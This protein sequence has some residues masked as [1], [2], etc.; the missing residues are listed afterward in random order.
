MKQQ[1]KK[2]IRRYLAEFENLSSALPEERHRILHRLNSLPHELQGYLLALLAERTTLNDLLLDTVGESDPEFKTIYWR[3]TKA[4]ERAELRTKEKRRRQDKALT[5]E[6]AKDKYKRIGYILYCVHRPTADDLKTLDDNSFTQ[7]RFDIDKYLRA[8]IDAAAEN[9]YMVSYEEALLLTRVLTTER[10]S[11]HAA[12]AS[13]IIELSA[14]F[15]VLSHHLL[16]YL[17]NAES[18]SRYPRPVN[19]SIQGDFYAP[20]EIPFE[21][22]TVLAQKQQPLRT[23]LRSENPHVSAL[24]A[25]QL[26][27][28]LPATDLD[29]SFEALIEVL[30]SYSEHW[31]ELPWQR[32]TVYPAEALCYFMERCFPESDSKEARTKIPQILRDPKVAGS[33][34]KL[35]LV[36]EDFPLKDLR[37]R[38][39]KLW[40]KYCNR[41]RTIISHSN[42]P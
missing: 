27:H 25:S 8:L 14:H 19:L 41:P 28:Q 10:D 30:C 42:S 24:A 31:D 1:R 20:K 23:A 32:V 39:R 18:Y 36:Y 4:L 3:I 33:I 38:L 29:E 5:G 11:G 12:K 34:S 26:R 7:V 16:S 40:L 37:K 22:A 9:I 13:H 15:R 17:E 6:I 21:H 2:R 35:I